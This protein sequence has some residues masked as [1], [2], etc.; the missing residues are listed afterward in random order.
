MI[1]PHQGWLI[2]SCQGL[3]QCPWGEMSIREQ[4]GEKWLRGSAEPGC[5][6]LSAVHMAL[7]KEALRE[8]VT[9]LAQSL[10]TISR[11]LYVGEQE[12]DLQVW[13]STSRAFRRKGFHVQEPPPAA[14]AVSP[15]S[16]TRRECRAPLPAPVPQ[17]TPSCARCPR[18]LAGYLG[19]GSWGKAPTQTTSE[20]KL[21]E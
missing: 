4:E 13:N 5:A 21:E 10:E 15:V 19:L 6:K 3:F 12:P 16:L 17:G 9:E 14:R 18:G 1:L 7:N 11:A 8:V 20:A 2:T